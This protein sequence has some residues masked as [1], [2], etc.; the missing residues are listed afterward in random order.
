MAKLSE[1]QAKLFTDTNFAVVSTIRDDGG[2]QSTVVWVDYDG[3]S[4]VFNT[5]T[6]RAKTQHLTEDPR[7]SVLVWD[8]DDPYRY[9][10]IAGE[11][12]LDEKDA[13][14]H[15]HGMSQKYTGEDWKNVENRVIVRVRPDRV[16]AHGV[17]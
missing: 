8:A 13:A 11:A 9:V 12:E 15:M 7:I 6:V 17:D 3:E 5:T 4:V 16:Y 14:E 2:P 1:N 10:E